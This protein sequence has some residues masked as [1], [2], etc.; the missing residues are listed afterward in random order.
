MKKL[1][2]CLLGVFAT[3]I[4]SFAQVDL[5]QLARGAAEANDYGQAAQYLDQLLKSEPQNVA[6]IHLYAQMYERV[7][8]PEL[9]AQMYSF[10]LKWVTNPEDRFTLRRSRAELLLQMGI[11]P[12][13][14]FEAKKL[15]EETAGNKN[16]ESYED[17]VLLAKSYLMLGDTV[18]A[19]STLQNDK[20]RFYRNP[21]IHVQSLLTQI[22]SEKKMV[23][24]TERE[25]KRLEK[26]LKSYSNHVTANPTEIEAYYLDAVL[27]DAYSA[28]F[29]ANILLERWETVATYYWE[30]NPNHRVALISMLVHN[31]KC[32]D[33][34]AN[35]LNMRKQ[36]MLS[37][38]NGDFLFADC[39]CQ[40]AVMYHLS[41]NY[42]KA[43]EYYFKG[44]HKDVDVE[45]RL[46]GLSNLLSYGCRSDV[47][48]KLLDQQ[49]KEINN[50]ADASL[51]LQEQRS[52][53]STRAFFLYNDGRYQEALEAQNQAGS[54]S[55]VLIG[56]IYLA[57][58]DNEKTLKFLDDLE[59]EMMEEEACNLMLTKAVTL[60]NLG[61]EDE[62]RELYENFIIMCDDDNTDL[63]VAYAALGDQDKAYSVISQALDKDHNNCSIFV[64]ASVV[65]CKLGNFSKAVDYLK[66][67]VEIDE[68]E[69]FRS[70]PVSSEIRECQEFI[71]F[72]NYINQRRKAL[73]E[74]INTFIPSD[75]Q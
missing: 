49:E 67:A 8:L 45:N 17:Y 52:L 36:E 50:I 53:M 42:A 62:S 21:E 27:S 39:C 29:S 37:K 15:I 46:I 19:I 69:T 26:A 10:G 6:A 54:S 11:Y 60:H 33:A 3:C 47:V 57:M 61:R 23:P 73:G 48:Y 55:S 32:I 51:R 75:L 64:T 20:M 31:E 70:L 12:S 40:V 25:L 41:K 63:A 38:Y 18:S 2:I 1:F 71:E 56:C 13:V 4:G 14:I 9:G 5:L 74:Q 65:E 34:I 28:L 58:G 30:L 16:T 22:V 44:Q 35:S 7:G 68:I 66:K 72:E 59:I 43:V 24:Q